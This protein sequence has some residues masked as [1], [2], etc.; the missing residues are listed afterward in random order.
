SVTFRGECLFRYSVDN[1]DK[2][3]NHYTASSSSLSL[4]AKN[5][6]RIWCSNINSVRLQV[7]AGGK[8]EDLSIGLDGHIQVED[9]KWVYSSNTGK[10]RLVVEEVN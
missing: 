4:N 9:I 6:I 10:Y 3:E 8:N 2:I 5:G 1:G 7:T